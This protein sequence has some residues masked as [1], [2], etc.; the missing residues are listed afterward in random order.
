MP[1]SKGDVFCSSYLGL[2]VGR[3]DGGRVH[4]G[5]GAGGVIRPI[6]RKDIWTTGVIAE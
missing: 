2:K 1:E 4:W 5:S 6:R 3:G